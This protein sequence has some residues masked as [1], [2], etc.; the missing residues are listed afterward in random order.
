MQKENECVEYI[1]CDECYKIPNSWN[2]WYLADDK[3]IRL[4]KNWIEWMNVKLCTTCNNKYSNI[5][6]HHS[7]ETKKVSTNQ[8]SIQ[9]ENII[10]IIVESSI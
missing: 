7:G 1:D 3:P 9:E 6:Y 2:K 4:P 8:V 10:K 5:S